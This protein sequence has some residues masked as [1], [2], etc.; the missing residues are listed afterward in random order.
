MKAAQSFM[1]L[2]TLGV[3]VLSSVGN[4]V[5]CTAILVTDMDGRAY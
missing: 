4:A 3:L 5:A 2:L 1:A